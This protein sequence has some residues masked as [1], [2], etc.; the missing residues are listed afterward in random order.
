MAKQHK[1]SRIKPVEKRATTY[2]LIEAC[3][4]R[5]IRAVE[6]ALAAGADANA[7]GCAPIYAT[8]NLSHRMTMEEG[9][10]ECTTEIVRLLLNN[11][12]DPNGIF[13][14]MVVPQYFGRLI[15]GLPSACASSSRP[16]QT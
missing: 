1:P 13:D 3:H 16:A 4:M 10:D 11:G 14:D 6:A 7:G 8:L 5:D 15:G 12:A 2:G 9:E